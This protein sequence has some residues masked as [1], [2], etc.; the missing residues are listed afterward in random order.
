MISRAGA[1]AVAEIT[2][3]GK[4]SILIPYPF[5]GRHQL[6]NA[7]VLNREGA[8]VLVEDKDLS[9]QILK[10]NIL[11]LMENP[12][13]LEEMSR[14]SAGLATPDAATRLS[15]EIGKMMNLK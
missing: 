14:K 15:S 11:R 10:E 5:A 6:Y 8:A 1:S 9:A 13:V 12:D 7:G 2:A 3:F 4:P